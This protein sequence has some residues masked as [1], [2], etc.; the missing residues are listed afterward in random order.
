MHVKKGDNVQI[1]SGG[2]K[3]KVGKVTKVFPKSSKIIV[4]NINIATK[5][6]KSSKAEKSGQIIITEMPIH[7]SRA[8]IYI[9][10]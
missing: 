8:M 9:K 2:E 1:I 3:G 6:I 5:H 7:S 4:E 10:K